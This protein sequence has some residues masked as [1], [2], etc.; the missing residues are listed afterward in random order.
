MNNGRGI[1]RIF[2]LA[3]K[4]HKVEKVSAIVRDAMV[5]P[6]NVLHLSHLGL[7]LFFAVLAGLY[8]IVDALY[9]VVLLKQ[10]WL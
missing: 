5:R 6:S 3:Y 4:L 10:R 9:F 2:E 1:G 8:A 7:M